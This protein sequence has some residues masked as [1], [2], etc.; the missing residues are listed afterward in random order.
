MSNPLVIVTGASRG[1]GE[2]LV[3]RLVEEGHYVA[4]LARSGDRLEA[5]ARRAEESGDHGK[6]IPCPVDVSDA[7]AVTELVNRLEAEHGPIEW[8]VNNA[9]VVQNVPFI[10]QSLDRIDEIID[11]NLKG[12]MYVTHAAIRH[13]IPRK[14]GRII[15]VASVAGIRGIEGQASYCASKHGMVGFSDALAQE[16]VAH[17]IPMAT[18]CPGAID[19]PL[20]DPETNPYPGDVSQTIQPKEIVDLVM[21][22]LGQPARTLFKRVV[23]FPNNE[24]H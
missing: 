5:L 6:V 11:T 18:I 15:Q 4:A 9:A 13:M 16:L 21:F 8:L 7:S 23:L 14:K 20:W 2:A 19:T 3:L 1:V 17:G 22:V 10:E 24:W 12:T